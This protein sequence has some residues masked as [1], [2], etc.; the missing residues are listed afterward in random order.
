[1]LLGIAGSKGSGK[2]TVG[3]YLVKEHNFER[4]S[5][6]DKLKQSAAA[7]FDLEP[8]ELER[9]KNEDNVY[10]AI[11]YENQP[12]KKF[13]GQP[14]MMW[15]PITKQSVRS[16]LQRYGTEAHR[17]IFGEDFW[18]N[19][20]LPVEGFYA[21]RA[22]CVTDC[23]FTNEYER[24]LALEG[25]VIV[26]DRPGLDLEDPHRSEQEFKEWTGTY[27]LD[28]SGTIYDLYANIEEMLV[29]LG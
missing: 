24:I 13:E 2:D 7:L 29:N 25:H 14:S 12:E 5:F 16:M 28:N 8:W 6:A 23:R 21:G 4:R 1:M 20:L 19:Q 10:V 3:A 18:V 15:S 27:R 9:M 17:D 26:V 22:I 11:G